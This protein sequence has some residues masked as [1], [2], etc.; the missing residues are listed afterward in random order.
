MKIPMNKYHIFI[1]K[2]YAACEIGEDN[3]V[4]VDTN[5]ISEIL[6]EEFYKVGL[7]ETEED[8]QK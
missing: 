3:V 1:T 4:L 6:E 2:L 7:L 8:D 5:K